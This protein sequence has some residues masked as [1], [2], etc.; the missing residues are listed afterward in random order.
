MDYRNI[1]ALAL[2]VFSMGHTWNNIQSA[3]AFPAGPNISMGSNPI[4]QS[5]KYC[6]GQ[7]NATILS[8]TTNQSFIVTDIVVTGG[9]ADILIDG[10][11]IMNL[12]STHITL[13]TGLR[14]DGGSVISCTDVGSYPRVT[15]VGYYTHT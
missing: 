10:N 3:H 2:L 14:V 1:L 5:Y 7:S 15:V 9:N 4:E 6:N 8:N 12:N 11:T 13:K